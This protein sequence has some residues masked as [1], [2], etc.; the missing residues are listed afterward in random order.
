[1][2]LV[3][4]VM[5]MIVMIVVTV[6]PMLVQVPSLWCR[7]SIESC[8]VWGSLAV[9]AVQFHEVLQ[10]FQFKYFRSASINS[11]AASS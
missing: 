8:Y 5:I 1:M 10:T 2:A 7:Y 4:R 3:V 9:V 11:S 6:T